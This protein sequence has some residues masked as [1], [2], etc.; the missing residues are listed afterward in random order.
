MTKPTTTDA[1]AFHARQRLADLLAEATRY[2][3]SAL[4][5]G[6]RP[7]K[8]WAGMV[9]TVSDRVSGLHELAVLAYHLDDPGTARDIDAAVNDVVAQ[10]ID[11]AYVAR[12][13]SIPGWDPATRSFRPAA[14]SAAP[15]ATHQQE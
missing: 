14:N 10:L 9:D 15:I 13:A 5:E 8:Q 3:A 1:I 6:G 4:R 11:L 2:H 12:M 7:S